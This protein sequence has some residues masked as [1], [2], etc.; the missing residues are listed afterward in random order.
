MSILRNSARCDD[1][2]DEIESVDRWDFRTC[3][4]GNL[5]VDGGKD[6]IRRGYKNDN[7][8]DTSIQE[9]DDLEGLVAA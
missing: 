3:W 1:C 2:G 4:C 7:W 8:T 5:F 6:Y 9:P